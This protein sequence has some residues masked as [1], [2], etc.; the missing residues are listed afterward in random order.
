MEKGKCGK[1]RHCACGSS[2]HQQDLPIFRDGVRAYIVC[3]Y[4]RDRRIYI[5]TWEKKPEKKSFVNVPSPYKFDRNPDL[6]TVITF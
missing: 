5:G 2:F 4:C 1:V 6:L 3:P